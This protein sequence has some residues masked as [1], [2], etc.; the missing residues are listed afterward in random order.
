MPGGYHETRRRFRLTLQCEPEPFKNLVKQYMSLPLRLLPLSSYIASF[1]RG[2]VIAIASFILASV[3]LI[4]SVGSLFLVGYHPPP[5][6]VSPNASRSPLSSK[7]AEL[8]DEKES[9]SSAESVL[10]LLLNEDKA[11][12]PPPPPPP[13]RTLE[14]RLPLGKPSLSV[15]ST[16]T[17][18]TSL[19]SLLRSHRRAKSLS[20]IDSAP[21]HVNRVHFHCRIN[22]L[23]T[24]KKKSESTSPP[25]PRTQP[26]GAPFFLPTPDTIYVPRRSVNPTSV[27]ST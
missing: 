25:R 3:G 17:S 22:S 5:P 6:R 16:R 14:R 13:R 23:K 7:P 19:R 11:S 21:T 12:P 10:G 20:S 27:P 9:N 1:T 2:L 24:H 18:L 15:P 4:L 8:L 26:Y